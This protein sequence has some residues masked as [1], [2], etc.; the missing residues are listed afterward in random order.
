M[1]KEIE[2]LKKQLERERKARKKAEE[3][4]ES[5]SL[6][7]FT[8][9]ENLR[10]VNEKL[11]EL[12]EERT[13]DLRTT[14]LRFERLV[15]TANDLIYRSDV[16]GYFSYANPVT[17]K[18]LGYTLEELKQKHF[19]ELIDPEYLD[20]VRE[21]YNAQFVN[22]TVGTYMELPVRTKNNETVWLGQNVIFQFNE[23]DKIDHISTVARNITEEK[24]SR[25]RLHN[26]IS[27]LQS[28]VLLEDEYRKIV[29][30]NERFCK[31]FGIEHA[32]ALLIGE[33]CENTI[34]QSK[35]L[36]VD[37][38]G[39]VKRIQEILKQR[40]LVLNDTLKLKDGRILE[41]DYIPVFIE[42]RYS[43][44]LW[45]YR[46]VTKQRNAVDAIRRSEEKYRGI[47]ENMNLGLMEVDTEERIL[48]ANQSFCEMSGYEPDEIIGKVAASLFVRGD[49]ASAIEEQ[50][51]MRQDGI[52]DVYELAIKNKRGQLKWWLISGGPLLDANGKR[53]GSIGIHYD[54]TQVKELQSDLEEAKFIAEESSKAK[55]IFLANM[56]HEIRT[57]MNGIVGMARQLDKTELDKNQSFYLNTIRNAA[58]NLL[59]I[60]ND[61]LDLSKIEAGKLSVENVPFD[62]RKSMK[63][64]S[65]VLVPKAEEKGLQFNTFI[66]DS[67]PK[68]ITGDPFRLN[69]VMLN[70]IGNAIK[71][72]EKG[73]V[74]VSCSLG[75][76]SQGNHSLHI[77]VK[78]DGIGMSPEYL[79]QIFEKFSQED[80]S[81]ARQFGGTGL[82]MNI[83]KQLVELMN[84]ELFIE[85]QKGEG[86]TV[87]VHIP[88]ESPDESQLRPQ[89]EVEKD[90]GILIGK[91]ILI[92]EDNE[93]N[94]L[95]VGTTLSN[96]GV[97]MTFAINGKEAVEHLQKNKFDLV[98][99][100]VQMPVM[101]GIEACQYIRNELDADIPILA[102]TANVIK[103]DKEKYLSAGMNDIV[104]KPFEEEHLLDIL[105][106]WITGK[107]IATQEETKEDINLSSSEYSLE[108]LQL[109]SRGNQDFVLKMLNIFYDQSEETTNLLKSSLKDED[110]TKIAKVA[111]KIKPSLDNLSMES[112]AAKAR[113]LENL[114]KGDKDPNLANLIGTF[115][116]DLEKIVAKMKSDTV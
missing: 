65:M 64:S 76:K 61:I 79:D 83:S 39:F 86:T 41:R 26:L 103:G 112:L 46:D 24:I 102:F 25:S 13:K 40:K 51:L 60:L 11:E 101:D 108:K 53:K 74:E 38:D 16:H 100:D 8:T 107:D 80:K 96:Y 114:P 66:E 99:M 106:K 71:F 27:N 15:E 1:N 3:V 75:N 52:S 45:N 14:E 42:N 21:F 22:K 109:I 82:G 70:L 56:S 62:F 44:H 111:H 20:E 4:L 84:G 2:L 77:S 88:F 48:Y 29:L 68:I 81:T 50:N 28:G 91:N 35:T 93:L 98:L 7:L 92:A 78:D 23:N 33:N 37:E 43:G 104:P 69:Q 59:V 34:E 55:E 6:E 10:E 63:Q 47:I 110:Y 73:K 90:Y 57:P 89:E 72:T 12:V 18:T 54:I 85:S 5:K 30:V 87:N 58:D 67:V 32:P 49:N 115:C 94:R 95:V 19:S 113:E 9:S 116:S 36:F 17:L 105:L 31:K 97:D